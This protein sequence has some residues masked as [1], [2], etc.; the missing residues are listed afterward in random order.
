MTNVVVQNHADIV[1]FPYVHWLVAQ[2]RS[3][4]PI[5]CVFW[6][7]TVNQNFSLC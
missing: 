2:S 3:L 1:I 5:G 7:I 6:F 4:G